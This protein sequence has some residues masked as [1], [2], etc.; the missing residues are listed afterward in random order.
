[1]REA[2]IIERVSRG[3]YQLADAPPISDPDLVVAAI[4]VPSAVVCLISALAFH[5]LTTQI[6]HRVDL[7]LA[8]GSR[9]PKLAHPPIQ[10]YRFGGRSFT[11]GVEEHSISGTPVR[12]FSAPKTIADC[13][14][15]R[16]KVG[17]D[18]A[19]EALRTYLRRRGSNMDDLLRFA[20]INRVRQIMMPYIE[21]IL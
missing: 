11:K 2:G 19:V 1:M 18:V 13:F 9:T 12:I 20:D 21:A 8:P 17:T 6:P 15:F 7:A 14:K 3:I 16:N 10:I 5:E 4:K